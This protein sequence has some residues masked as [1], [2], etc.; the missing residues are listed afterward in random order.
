V[1][2]GDW[3]NLDSW[4]ENYGA[5]RSIAHAPTAVPLFDHQHL[6]TEWEAIDDWT[7]SW[8]ESTSGIRESSRPPADP[9]DRSAT[10]WMDLDSWWESYAETGHDTAVQIA[11][12]LEKST[13]QWARSDAP[14]DTDPLAADLT[15]DRDPRGPL[16]PTGELSWSRWLTRVLAT[17]DALVRELFD[18]PV[19]EPP[20]EVIRDYSLPRETG[21]SRRADIVVCHADHGVSVEVKLGD[22]NYGK[23]AETARLVEEHYPEREWEHVLLLPRSK[24]ERLETIVSPPVRPLDDRQRH[25][26]WDDPGPVAVV[27]W[28]DV[29][30]AIRAV[31]RH[32]DAVD[33]HWAANAYLLCSMIEQELVGFQPANVITRFT[34]P[35]SVAETLRPTATA[36]TL[37]KQLSYLRARVET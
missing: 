29:A 34:E 30:A 19:D 32:G 28:Q 35:T 9:N 26:M 14:F 33:D 24:T 31:L 13:D 2:A 7:Q 21:R 20:R 8:V 15:E 5:T 1:G 22:E 4:W 10:W 12:L 36:D 18:V 3:D 37:E 17:S 23:T 11:D 25:V 6:S 27:Y 16:R